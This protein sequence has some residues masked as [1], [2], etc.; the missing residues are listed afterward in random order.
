MITGITTIL[1]A[2]SQTSFVDAMWG[3]NGDRKMTV[4]NENRHNIREEAFKLQ[5]LEV[6]D[7]ERVASEHSSG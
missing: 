7:L 2:L 6:R 1:H 3:D 4:Y 5:G